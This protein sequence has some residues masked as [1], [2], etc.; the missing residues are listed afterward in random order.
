MDGN[1]IGLIE[2]WPRTAPLIREFDPV[3]RSA[4]LGYWN[5]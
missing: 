1:P 3:R 2:G 5:K 4:N